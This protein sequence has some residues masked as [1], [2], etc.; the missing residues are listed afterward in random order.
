MFTHKSQEKFSG[1]VDIF[2]QWLE[3]HWLGVIKYVLEKL[4]H[5]RKGWEIIT[6]SHNFVPK[7]LQFDTLFIDFWLDFRVVAILCI[8]YQIIFWQ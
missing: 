6:E 8:V 5:G 4:S 2:N 3:N 1:H 7:W